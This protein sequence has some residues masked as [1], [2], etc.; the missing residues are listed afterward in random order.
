MKQLISTNFN[1]FLKISAL[2]IL[3]FVPV[4]IVSAATLYFSP[5]AKDV[6]VGDIFVAEVRLNTEGS[7]INAVQGNIVIPAGIFE[8]VDTGKGDSILNLWA[9]EPSYS[10]ESETL[11]FIGGIPGGFK[12]DAKILT[13][14][15]KAIGEGT[16]VVSFGSDSFVLLNDGM[17]TKTSLNILDMSVRA[18]V[19]SNAVFINEW[20]EISGEDKTPPENFEVK[21]GRQAAVYEGKYF[22]SFSTRDSGSG[23]DY[24]QVKEGE[25]GEW[26]LSQSPRVLQDQNL[27]GIIYV[28]A[29]DRA[30][31]ETIAEL[32]P[33]K[34]NVWYLYLW[35]LFIPILIFIFIKKSKIKYQKSKI[36]IKN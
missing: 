21:I 9:K 12:G 14:V 1:K 32:A 2:T 16:A 19:Q 29:V 6:N 13:L 10:R 31:N 18:S 8:F 27:K 4:A 15:L 11:S 33:R 5:S 24:Y 3:L 28:K 20:E 34:K 22:I 7:D 23:I 25:D 26:Q 30:G 35:I 36:H 17:G